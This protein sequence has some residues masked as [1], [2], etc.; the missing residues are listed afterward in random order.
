MAEL[1]L[2]NQEQRVFNYMLSFGGITSL[3]AYNDLGVSQLGARIKSLE[4]KGIKIYRKRIKVYNRFQE[5]TNVTF[6]SL[7]DNNEEKKK[8]SKE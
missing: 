3:Q 7:T 6:Y 5:R 8:E 1:K 4:A 2:N